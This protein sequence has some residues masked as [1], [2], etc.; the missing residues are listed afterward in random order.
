M[1]TK[2]HIKY[3]RSLH[4]KKYRDHNKHFIVEGEKL[5]N[6]AIKSGKEIIE[7]ICTDKTKDKI[8]Y[9]DIQ[10]VKSA[11]YKKLSIQKT[12][13]EVLAILPYF[14]VTEAPIRNKDVVFALDHVQDPGN[15]GTIIR[16][17]DWFGIDHLICS[18]NTVDQY[19]P[20]VVQSSMGSIFR[21]NVHYTSLK[22]YFKKATLESVPIY[23]GTMSGES[24]YM[25]SAISKGIIVLGNES[26]GIHKEVLNMINEEISIPGAYRTDSLNVAVSCGIFAF[27]VSKSN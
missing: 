8:Y 12:P 21:I 9:P 10:I 26:K 17:C 22:E 2:N 27:W 6:E 14:S 1:I 24:I 23:A 13:A 4:Q 19:N 7:I 15:L 11:E 25:K 3:I 20:K 18:E 16:I 5:V